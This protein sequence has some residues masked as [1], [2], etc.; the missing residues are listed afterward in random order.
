MASLLESDIKKCNPD[1]NWITF[2]DGAY[3]RQTHQK[4]YFGFK[5]SNSLLS[6]A[7]VRMSNSFGFLHGMRLSAQAPA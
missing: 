4:I 1:Q 2:V 3:P 7:V 6:N 5:L